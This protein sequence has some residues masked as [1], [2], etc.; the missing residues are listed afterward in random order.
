MHIAEATSCVL[1][2]G[3]VA[4]ALGTTT[5]VAAT[6]AH[7]PVAI[8]DRILIDRGALTPELRALLARPIA[9]PR[10]VPLA[11]DGAPKGAADT[12][13]LKPGRGTAVAAHGASK[14]TDIGPHPWSAPGALAWAPTPAVPPLLTTPMSKGAPRIDKVPVLEDRSLRVLEHVMMSRPANRSGRSRPFAKKKAVSTQGRL[15]VSRQPLQRM[16]ARWTDPLASLDVD[17]AGSATAPE[18]IMPFANGRVTSLF[19]Q[20]RRHPAIDL[21]GA[22]GSPVLATTSPQTVVFAGGRGGYGNAVIT[23]DRFGWTHLYGHLK[24]ITARV[25]QVLSQGDKLGHLGSTGYSTGPHVHYEVRNGKGQHVNPVTLLF[26]GRGVGKGYAWLDVRQEQRSARVVASVDAQP[27]K[28]V[29][30]VAARVA[31]VGRNAQV[32]RRSPPRRAARAAIYSD[33]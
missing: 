28:R 6:D 7:E 15:P 9:G 19:N 4:I 8:K 32:G 30:K 21:A 12:A 5:A 3:Y 16:S 27:V 14:V 25:G 23:R 10:I 22:L 11:E 2:A 18:F 17:D 24:S 29:E 26:P 33:E 20:G 13:A 31:M 1:A